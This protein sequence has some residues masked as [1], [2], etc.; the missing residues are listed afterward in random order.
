MERIGDWLIVGGVK[1]GA[2]GH[3]GPVEDV[4]SKL[5]FSTAAS[6]WLSWTEISVLANWFVT[7]LA[8]HR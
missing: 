8:V 7:M 1:G 3:G 2:G 4:L 5:A 6:G